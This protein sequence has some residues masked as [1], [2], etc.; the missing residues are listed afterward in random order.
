MAYVAR[1]DRYQFV[2]VNGK[3]EKSYDEI[4][5]TG[6]GRKIV[7]DSPDRLHYLAKKGPAIYL[8]GKKIG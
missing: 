4:F 7:F 2:V 8:V 3:E 5:A 6:E 1:S